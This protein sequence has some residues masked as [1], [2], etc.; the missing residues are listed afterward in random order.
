MTEL[1]FAK[2][3]IFREYPGVMVL[4]VI[5]EIIG[6][7][8]M[9][10]GLGTIIPFISGLLG[11]NQDLPGPLGDILSEVG[12]FQWSN[13]ATLWFIVALMTAKIF[14]DAARLYI[15]G[16]IGVR[17]NL[18]IKAFMNQAIADTD[19]LSF[20]GINQ[21]KYMQCMVVE[22]SLA[23]GAVSD[24]AAAFA[25]GLITLLLLMWMAIYSFQIFVIISVLGAIFI[26]TN[27]NLMWALHQS[28]QQR[29]DITA[30]MNVKVTDTRH[31]FKILFA[32]NLVSAMSTSIRVIIDKLADVEKRQLFL[33]VFIENYV[34]FFGLLVVVGI[35]A[36]HF[37]LPDPNVSSLLF[38]LVLLQ[39]ITSYFGNF[40]N[41]RKSML[42]KIP[43][44]EASLEMMQLPR[45]DRLDNHKSKNI[46]SIKDGIQIKDVTFSY[47]N[48]RKILNNF[49]AHL[50]SHGLVFFTGP[51]GSG[52]TTTIDL[53]VGLLTPETGKVFVDGVDLKE[54]NSKNWQ[55]LIAYVPQ[56]A[57]ILTGSLRN[58]LTFGCADTT[59]EQIWH[60]L[61]LAHA[62]HIVKSSPNRLDTLVKLGGNNF[63]GG[64]RQ[65]LSIARALIRGVKILF[66]DEPTSALDKKSEKILFNTLYELSE[67]ILIIVVTHARDIIR[68]KDHRFL[69][70]NGRLVKAKK[71]ELLSGQKI[72]TGDS[73]A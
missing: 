45:A 26:W 53:L 14:L 44:Y 42:Q 67:E 31:I 29:I 13:I 25:Y 61:K 17:L 20:S 12:I 7:A 71:K 24:L 39:R 19:W 60:A 63:S 68:D 70:E 52:K 2:R 43:S 1:E 37:M 54:L 30:Q 64:E 4:L 50:L 3:I 21:G 22:S 38:D 34:A 5:N 16:A 6:V 9:L 73:G 36:T 49:N 55:S 57:Y 47:D 35:S 10:L 65:R 66:L 8:L 51:S 69:F 11:G 33:A 28:S 18:R 41:K 58:Y 56:E 23:R 62:E 32:E 27:R 15:A 46:D 72:S 48:S 40:Q 59:D